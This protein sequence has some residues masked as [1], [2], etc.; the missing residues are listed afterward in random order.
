MGLSVRF[1]APV[2]ALP[3]AFRRPPMNRLLASV[4]TF[5]GG[6]R[7]AW[8]RAR[9]A[10]ERNRRRAPEKPVF[11][12]FVGRAQHLIAEKLAERGNFHVVCDRLGIAGTDAVRSG[13]LFTLPRF[14]DIRVVFNLLRELEQRVA[15]AAFDAGYVFGGV[16]YGRMLYRC[17]LETLRWQVWP[18]LIVVAQTRKLQEVTGPSALFVNGA[19]NEPMGN[20]IAFNRHSGLPIYLMPHGMDLQKFA[21]FMPAV[22][23]THV[24]YLAYGKEHSDYF[25]AYLDETQETRQVLVGNPLTALMNGTRRRRVA[26]R[27][28]RLLVMSFGHLEFWNSARVYA[29]DQY[30]IEIF[31]VLRGLLEQGWTVGIRPHPSHPRDLENRLAAAFGLDRSIRWDDTPTFEEALGAYDVVVCSASTTFYQSLYAGWPTIFYEPDYRKIGGIE[32][33]END[34][35]FTGL[36]TARDLKRPVT[37]DPGTLRRMI[38]DSLDPESMV[39]TFP[40]RFAGELAPRFIGPDPERADELIADF[41]ERDILGLAQAPVVRAEKGAA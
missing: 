25:R 28:K 18:F 12:M 23:N 33:I 39:A 32:G 24:T 36:L 16:D 7:P 37:N 1:I 26:S 13:H 15:T 4:R 3:A 11:Y 2:N 17:I 38:L 20:L 14:R 41:L 19:G 34:P 9:K 27:G 30:Y 35:M 40:R 10:F 29:V 5:I 22:D 6:F 21:Y 8:W 31:D